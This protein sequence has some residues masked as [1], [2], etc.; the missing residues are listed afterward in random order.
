MDV[1]LESLL[2]AFDAFVNGDPAEAERTRQTYE[3]KVA[4][5]ARARSIPAEA[6]DRAVQRTYQRWQ[7][8][9]DPK[10]PRDLRKL[11]FD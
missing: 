6:L 4:E 9:D 5:V 2:K 11:R 3:E 1:D 10:F 8:A 7:W